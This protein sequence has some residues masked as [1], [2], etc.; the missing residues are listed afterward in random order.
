[1]GCLPIFFYS[2][3]NLIRKECYRLKNIIYNALYWITNNKTRFNPLHNNTSIPYPQYQTALAELALL[4]YQF[5]RKNIKVTEID[6]Y[7]K[8]IEEVYSKPIFYK[9]PFDVDN[10]AFIGH[11][12]IWLALNQR[13]IKTPVTREEIQKFI[14]KSGI[15]SISRHGFRNLELRY[16][17]EKGD[18]IHDMDDEE[19]LFE[20]TYL[21]RS[22]IVPKSFEDMY[23]ITHTIFYL[24]DFG[25]RQNNILKSNQKKIITLVQQMICI[26][27]EEGNWDLL[28]ELVLCCYL[29]DLQDSIDAEKIFKVL[30]T[31]QY[32]EG[33]I[34]GFGFSKDKLSVIPYKE[35]Q[36]EYIFLCCYH[37]TLVTVMAGFLKKNTASIYKNDIMK[38]K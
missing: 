19:S 6:D 35:Y 9:Y 12:I 8:L 3:R 14:V 22:S 27:L 21:G 7:I 24:T 28:G 10:R 30:E 20:K 16:Y 33:F 23:D 34:P 32:E 4:C 31:V 11:L 38:K 37:P 36:D 25:S 15:T 26:V 17:L 1:M 5:H 13:G 18:F 29:T 2:L